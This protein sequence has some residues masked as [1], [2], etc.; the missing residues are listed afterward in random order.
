ME[1]RLSLLEILGDKI[2]YYHL[3]AN[4]NSHNLPSAAEAMAMMSLRR[5]APTDSNSKLEEY[6]PL[7][8]SLLRWKS[9]FKLSNLD[10]KYDGMMSLTDHVT[11]FGATMK[12][13]DALDDVRGEEQVKLTNCRINL[14]F[15]PALQR[16]C[17]NIF[18]EQKNKEKHCLP[19]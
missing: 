2:T 10:K 11:N 3:G 1:H 19:H 13:Q 7:C 16:V 17:P 6:K 12:L 18:R 5:R 4:P 8:S 14:L 15:F 9:I